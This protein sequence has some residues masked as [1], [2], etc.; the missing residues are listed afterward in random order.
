MEFSMGKLRHFNYFYGNFILL[1]LPF[2]LSLR[3]PCSIIVK[4]IEGDEMIL[5]C[6][7]ANSV[8]KMAY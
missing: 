8:C 6:Y 7:S 1:S 5:G 2:S 3:V 4:N